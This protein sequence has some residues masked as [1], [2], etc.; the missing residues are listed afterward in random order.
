MIG[1]W[2]VIKHQGL[3]DLLKNISQTIFFFG[4]REGKPQE[5]S[6]TIA[7]IPKMVSNYETQEQEA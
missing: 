1:E 6:M 2:H 3:S 5:A 7:R 4:K